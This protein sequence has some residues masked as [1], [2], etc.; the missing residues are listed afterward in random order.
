[1]YSRLTHVALNKTLMHALKRNLLRKCI[2]KTSFRD[3]DRLHLDHTIC[4]GRILH[5][6]STVLI[7]CKRQS[8][9][10]QCQLGTGKQACARSPDTRNWCHTVIGSDDTDRRIFL[11]SKSYP[12]GSLIVEDSR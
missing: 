3:C 11:R 5:L 10:R 1:M 8:A 7:W 6:L 9:R 4:Q 12:W 2:Y